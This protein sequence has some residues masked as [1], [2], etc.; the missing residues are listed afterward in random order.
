[1]ASLLNPDANAIV[2]IQ[3]DLL[4]TGK[5]SDLTIKNGEQSFR[6]HRAI[7]CPR[8]PFFMK[9]CDGPFKVPLLA[10]TRY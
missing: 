7:V 1:M 3:Q 4:R 9:A 2:A 10:E 6:V 5:Y 8:S